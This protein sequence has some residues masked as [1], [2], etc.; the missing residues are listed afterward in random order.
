MRQIENIADICEEEEEED[1]WSIDGWTLPTETQ[2]P[3]GQQ[4]MKSMTRPYERL[5]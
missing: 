5:L 1:D 2:E 4:T 3:P